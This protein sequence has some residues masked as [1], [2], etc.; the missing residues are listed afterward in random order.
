M[1]STDGYLLY[2]ESAY[3]VE[4]VPPDQLIGCPQ[5]TVTSIYVPS[6]S[7]AILFRS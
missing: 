2:C 4:W 5:S 7:S 6:A 1:L 3:S